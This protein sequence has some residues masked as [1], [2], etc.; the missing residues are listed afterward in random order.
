MIE[1]KKKRRR[2]IES[3][4]SDCDPSTVKPK[5]AEIE[6]SGSEESE[7]SSSSGEEYDTTDS[8]SDFPKSSDGEPETEVESEPESVDREYKPSKKPMPEM[9]TVEVAGVRFQWP[10]ALVCLTLE[11][12]MEAMNEAGDRNVHSV[13][14]SEEARGGN[15]NRQID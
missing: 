9:V 11:H 12:D 14:I 15:L 2:I 1:K 3:D 6:E 4:D 10:T 13:H 7:E 8:D 5:K